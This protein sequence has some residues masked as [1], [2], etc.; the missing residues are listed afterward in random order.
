[1]VQKGGATARLT[2]IGFPK[3]ISDRKF[4]TGHYLRILYLP[5]TA[6]SDGPAHRSRA[7]FYYPAGISRCGFGTV[8]GGAVGGYP[9]L[10]YTPHGT[11]SYIK[12]INPRFYYILKIHTP[13]TLVRLA[14]EARALSRAAGR[15]GR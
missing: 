4:G 10:P 14:E 5:R 7:R 2:R 1:M 3:Q 9:H 15:V 13:P 8:V 6:F 12:L 11:V